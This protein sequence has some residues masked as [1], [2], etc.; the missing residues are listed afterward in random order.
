MPN[1]ARPPRLPCRKQGAIGRATLHERHRQSVAFEMDSGGD[2][3]P[4]L[5]LVA[6]EV[7]SR[8][9]K[10]APQ[11]PSPRLKATGYEAYVQFKRHSLLFTSHRDAAVARG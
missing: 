2:T 6:D 9:C 8:G 1:T 5:H 4:A 11:I 3:P 10:Y 7:T